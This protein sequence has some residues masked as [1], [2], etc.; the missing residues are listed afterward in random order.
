MSLP[1]K[2][3]SK[4]WRWGCCPWVLWK[5]FLFCESLQKNGLVIS[6]RQVLG[7]SGQGTV[8]HRALV[9]WRMEDCQCI[10][11]SI[12]LLIWHWPSVT[13]W[14]KKSRISWIFGDHSDVLSARDFQEKPKENLIYQRM[15]K[16]KFCSVLELFCLSF[17]SSYWFSFLPVSMCGNFCLQICIKMLLSAMRKLSWSAEKEQSNHK[18]VWRW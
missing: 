3:T 1:W 13:F 16:S 6:W 15:M 11:D 5:L 17:L 4:K 7:H 14:E 10:P 9:L 18:K 8:P 2:W 12:L